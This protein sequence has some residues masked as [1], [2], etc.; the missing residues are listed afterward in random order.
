MFV[1]VE[2]TRAGLLWCLLKFT[3]STVCA[4]LWPGKQVINCISVAVNI[5]IFIFKKKNYFYFYFHLYL[6]LYLYLSHLLQAAASFGNLL[7]GFLLQHVLLLPAHLLQTVFIPSKK[8][9]KSLS[10]TQNFKKCLSPKKNLKKSLS[11]AIFLQKSIHLLHK[12]YIARAIQVKLG[13]LLFPT[14]WNLEI[15]ASY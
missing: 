3:A 9:N 13:H 2:N 15:V 1:K 4:V 7:L 12:Q 14:S 11:T 10:P 8:V 5:F 6:Y